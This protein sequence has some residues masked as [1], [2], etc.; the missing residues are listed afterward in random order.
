[1]NKSMGLKLYDANTQ[2]CLYNC[3][4][5][6]PLTWPNLVHAA[7]ISATGSVIRL[8]P[9]KT[10]NSSAFR[11]LGSAVRE[12]PSMTWGRSRV[13]EQACQVRL[14][15]FFFPPGTFFLQV[16]TCVLLLT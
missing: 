11:P 8:T 4:E 12:K 9:Q 6:S 13:W 5:K 1:M 10:S 2:V 3:L 15:L 16:L 14:D 7:D